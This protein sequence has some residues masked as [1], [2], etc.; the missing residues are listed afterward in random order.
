MIVVANDPNLGSQSLPAEEMARLMLNYCNYRLII[1]A[2]VRTRF[3]DATDQNPSG[4]K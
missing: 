4:V 1:P 3:G 2:V